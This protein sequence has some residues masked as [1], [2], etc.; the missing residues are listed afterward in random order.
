MS[1][2]LSARAMAST[3]GIEH[4]SLENSGEEPEDSDYTGPVCCGLILPA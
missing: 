1:A 2:G 3:W 4:V